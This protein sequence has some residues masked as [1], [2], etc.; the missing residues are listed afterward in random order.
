MADSGDGARPGS[1][2]ATRV[3]PAGN[4]RLSADR[5][6]E[7]YADVIKMLIEVG[8]ASLTMDGIAA[9]SRVSKATLYRQWQGKA[10]LVAEALRHDNPPPARIDTGSLHGDLLAM[11]TVLGD[12]APTDAPLLA[13][14]AHASYLDPDLGAALRRRLFAP[15]HAILRDI[16]NRAVERG[17]IPPGSPALE[18]SPLVF[19]AMMPGRA[20]FEGVQVTPEYLAGFVDHILLPALVGSSPT[21]SPP[22][23]P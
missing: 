7:I 4:R 13:S 22:A 11:T 5:V 21:A 9:R 8:Y 12:V 19:M 6:G 10:D 20:L 1:T 3:R 17:E 18:F 16:L 2:A 23:G 15:F 14:L